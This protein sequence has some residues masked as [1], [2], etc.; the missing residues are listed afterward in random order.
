MDN[1]NAR[2][3]QETNVVS[4]KK[5]SKEYEIT[6]LREGDTIEINLQESTLKI[7]RGESESKKTRIVFC[8][9][10]EDCIHVDH[11]EKIEIISKKD[12]KDFTMTEADAEIFVSVISMIT[13]LEIKNVQTD[14][15]KRLLRFKF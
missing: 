9:E 14:N 15:V 12:H 6:D 4:G 7:T 10:G 2:I 11:P 5:I 13:G 1:R 8:R 3:I